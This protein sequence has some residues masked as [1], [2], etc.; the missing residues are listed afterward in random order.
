MI[1]IPKE[2]NIVHFNPQDLCSLL[3]LSWKN[4]QMCWFWMFVMN[5]YVLRKISVLHHD[6]LNTE[7]KIASI[8][9]LKK[10]GQGAQ[11]IEW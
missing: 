2:A 9:I 3:I 6:I 4:L 8:F 7:K 10:P 5:L 1:F 11:V